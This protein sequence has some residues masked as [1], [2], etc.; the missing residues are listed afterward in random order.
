[1]NHLPEN[2]N[3]ILINTKKYVDKN[4]SKICVSSIVANIFWHVPNT[5]IVWRNYT[6]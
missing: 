5:N 2:E 3:R 6:N 1:M 4:C